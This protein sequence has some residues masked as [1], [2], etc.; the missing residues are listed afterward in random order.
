MVCSGA[1]NCNCN[2][3]DDIDKTLD[4]RLV[5]NVKVGDRKRW[6]GKAVKKSW[7]RE[8]FDSRIKW[9]V[10]QPLQIDVGPCKQANPVQKSYL[11]SITLDSAQLLRRLMHIFKNIKKKAQSS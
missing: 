7:G 3:D 1:L 10:S 9:Q 11:R 6:K 5:R 2:E 4:S 8:M